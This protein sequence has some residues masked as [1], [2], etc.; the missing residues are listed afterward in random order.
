LVIVPLI[1]GRDQIVAV[2]QDRPDEAV[3]PL[4]T[5]RAQVGVEH[6]AGMGAERLGHGEDRAEGRPL[7]GQARVGEGVL[8]G[9]LRLGVEQQHLLVALGGGGQ[10]GLAGAVGGVAVRHDDEAAAVGEVLA[11]T[12]LDGPYDVPDGVRV[13]ER[14]D[15]DQKVDGVVSVE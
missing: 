2:V 11:E 4:G 6:G 9:N 3:D 14:R 13:L 1:G 8:V 12:G 5:D 10:R 7:A 15:A